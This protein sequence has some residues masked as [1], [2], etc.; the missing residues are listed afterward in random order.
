MSPNGIAF[1]STLAGFALGYATAYLREWL[2]AIVA[3]DRAELER[4]RRLRGRR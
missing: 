1:V 4:L 3:R 2:T